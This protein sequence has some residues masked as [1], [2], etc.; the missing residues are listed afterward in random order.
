MFACALC[1]LAPLLLSGC[2]LVSATLRIEHDFAGGAQQSTGSTVTELP[3]DLAQDKDYKDHRDKI[4]SVDEVAF[5]FR[6]QNNR[7]VD[8]QAEVWLS[9]SPIAPLTPDAVRHSA[10]ARRVLRGLVLPADSVVDVDYR[11]SLDLQENTEYLYRAVR[12]GTFYLYAIADSSEFDLTI[13]QL[14]A[15]VVLTVEL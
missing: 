8:T 3:F 12:E 7:P 10:D 13:D 14:T 5:L 9:R 11:T 6:A 15:I 2:N 1:A 4:V